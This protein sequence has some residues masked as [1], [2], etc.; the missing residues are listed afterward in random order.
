MYTLSTRLDCDVY[1][2][3]LGTR[4][5]CVLE[6][7]EPMLIDVDENRC[8]TFPATRFF[9][10]FGV[11]NSKQTIWFSGRYRHSSP[12]STLSKYSVD[13]SLHDPRTTN[14]DDNTCENDILFFYQF[15]SRSRLCVL[16]CVLHR[17]ISASSAGKME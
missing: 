2:R 5:K 9:V 6:V 14:H 13:V 17:K 10:Y 3:R 11:T 8:I 4:L 16:A 12:I 15:L 7:C 1:M